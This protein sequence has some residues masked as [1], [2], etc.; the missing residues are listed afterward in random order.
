[1]I[2]RQ[3]CGILLITTA[4]LFISASAQTDEQN[5]NLEKA[6]RYVEAIRLGDDDGSTYY[7]A[8]C[9]FALAGKIEEAFNYLEQSIAHGYA[10]DEHIKKDSDLDS[11]RSDARWQIVINKAESKRREIESAFYN[12]K[13]FWDNPALNTSYKENLS[14]DEK[15]AGLSKFW[16]EVKYNFVNFDLVPDLDWDALYLAYLPKVRATKSTLEYYRVLMEMCARLRDGHTNVN[17]PA[18]LFN[19]ISARPALRSRLIEDKVLIVRVFD[20]ALKQQGIEQGQ[21]ILEINNVPVK[22]YAERH[23]KPYQSSSTAQDME[24]R[25]YDY[26]LLSGAVKSSLELTLRDARGKVFKRSVPRISFE[27]RKKRLAQQ[28]PLF[29]FKMLPVNLAYVT[30]NSFDDKQVEEMFAAAYDPIAKAD[31]IIFD[32]RENGGGSSDIGW[33]IIGYLTDKPFPISSWYTR[34]YRPSFRA[35][36]R[37][38]DVYGKTNEFWRANG[39]HLYNKPVVVLTSP[40]VFSAAE[41]FVVAFKSLK[42]GLIIGEPT[43][44][45]TGQPLTFSLP[46]GGSARVCTK[47]DKFPNGQDFVGKGI[48]PDKVVKPTVS[49]FR[50]GRDTVLDA[51]L[52]SLKQSQ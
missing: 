12:Q 3:L 2:I 25:M 11:L 39:K 52:K 1:M 15:I 21:E 22:Q 27:E 41:D 9:S 30:L 43:G 34:D 14:E 38:Q 44:G 47:R 46:G 5:Q 42:R 35:W 33:D 28:T 40:R 24:T 51:A 20:D 18:E 8:A 7:N 50:A 37:P 4:L 6:K 13:T 45:S 16:S 29:E 48:E 19:E 17:P 23:V 26:A 32:V 31:A 49:D 36:N 10:D